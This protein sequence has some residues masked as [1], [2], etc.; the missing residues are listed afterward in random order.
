MSPNPRISPTAGRRRAMTLVEMSISIAVMSMVA[1]SASML[2]TTVHDTHVAA[3]HLNRMTQHGRAACRRIRDALNRAQANSVFPGFIVRNDL[4]GGVSLPNTL[5]VWAPD[6]SPSDPTALPLVSELVV[7][8]PDP[9]DPRRLVEITDPT[10][11]STVPEL[12]DTTSWNTLMTSLENNGKRATLTRYLH[13][14]TDLSGVP[15][16]LIRFTARLRPDQSQIDAYIAETATWDD[17]YWPQNLYSSASGMRENECLFEFQLRDD[18]PA[19][20]DI[21]TFWGSS[22][23]FYLEPQP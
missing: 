19:V 6:V 15:M 11:T 22:A 18:P 12:M 1:L 10:D 7:F 4:I 8:Q 2:T 21:T 17:I 16:S 13:F 14:D 9:D 23:V 3:T 20:Q 5:V